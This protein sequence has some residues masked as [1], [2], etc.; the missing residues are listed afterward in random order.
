M[1]DEPLPRNC[2]PVL[3]IYS[4]FLENSRFRMMSAMDGGG[5]LVVWKLGRNPQVS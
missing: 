4:R 2:S 5:E 3:G 1:G